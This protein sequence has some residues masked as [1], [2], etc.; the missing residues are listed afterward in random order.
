MAPR[1]PTWD[2][3]ARGCAEFQHF[4]VAFAVKEYVQNVVGQILKDLRVREWSDWER[5]DLR[6]SLVH[7]VLAHLSLDPRQSP[8]MY[9]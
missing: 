5:E 9:P 7:Y 8:R 6:A 3:K 2:W 4:T 1:K